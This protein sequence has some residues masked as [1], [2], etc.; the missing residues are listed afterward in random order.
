M[1]II[2][3]ALKNV[4]WQPRYANY[5]A[6]GIRR[7]GHNVHISSSTRPEPCDISILMGPNSFKS[8]EK[9]THI[10]INRKLIGNNPRDVHDTVAVSW[11]GF[12]GRGTFCV[13]EVDPTRLDRYIKPSDIE[14]WRTGGKHLLLIEQSNTGRSTQYNRLNNY[15]QKV[16]STATSKVVIRKKPIGESNINPTAV[17]KGLIGAK[18]VVN[19]NSTI[20]VTISLFIF[21][22]L[23]S[24]IS[25]LLAKV[26]KKI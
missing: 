4:T 25:S 16:R 11:N 12:N 17:R 23:T 6:T 1:K 26:W 9:R 10:M 5:I 15:Y 3:H 2:I 24:T 14:D 20:Y 22:L 7:H 19:L 8:I 18:A 21:F 13:N